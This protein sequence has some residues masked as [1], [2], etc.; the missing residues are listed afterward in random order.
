M[1]SAGYFKAMHKKMLTESSIEESL[2]AVCPCKTC[3]MV[4]WE[5]TRVLL[6]GFTKWL[7]GG[8][9]LAQVKR[10]QYLNVYGAGFKKVYL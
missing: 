8:L 6:C 3:P 5:I 7:L 9:L 2:N 1:G 10:G 4:L